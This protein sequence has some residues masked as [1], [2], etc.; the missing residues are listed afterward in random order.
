VPAPVV[1]VVPVAPPEVVLPE[2][3][4]LRIVT[5][6]DLMLALQ[7]FERATQTHVDTGTPATAERYESARAEV[8]RELAE[9]LAE[10]RRVPRFPSAR[11]G[12]AVADYI[13]SAAAL[14]A[15]AK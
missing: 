7:R 14:V 2:K 1:V 6:D 9:Y 15:L 5:S 4:S 13:A 11:V 8:E 12:T 3:R 10:A